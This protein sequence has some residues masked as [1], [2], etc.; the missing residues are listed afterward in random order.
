VTGGCLGCLSLR[1]GTRPARS[2]ARGPSRRCCFSY[3]ACKGCERSE[4]RSMPSRSR[5]LV[6]VAPPD[7]ALRPRRGRCSTDLAAHQVHGRR[8]AGARLGCP[9]S[10]VMRFG[11]VA[12][13][14]ALSSRPSTP[15]DLVGL[16]ARPECD[17]GTVRHHGGRDSRAN[18]CDEAAGARTAAAAA[19]RFAQGSPTA[20]PDERGE[21]GHGRDRGGS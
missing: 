2:G 7:P 21:S 9:S 3:R 15:A 1:D 19:A 18:W 14:A 20:W 5:M 6:G 13:R 12:V 11:T 10:S 8:H 4:V 17:A 16:L